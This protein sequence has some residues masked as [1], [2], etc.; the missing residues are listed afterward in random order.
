MLGHVKMPARLTIDKVRETAKSRGY[1]LL[2]TCF[3]DAKTKI[4]L[5][6]PKHGVFEQ[7]IG[8]L[9]SGYGCQKCGREKISESIG[10]SYEETKKIV[11]KEGYSL[12][13]IE[14]KKGIK[15]LT[16]KCDKHG[17]FIQRFHLFRSGHRCK[18][19]SSEQFKD[20]LCINTSDAQKI[21]DSWGYKGFYPKNLGVGR[22]FEVECPKHGKILTTLT[23]LRCG[24]GCFDCGVEKN[25]NKKRYSQDKIA[26]DIEKKGYKLLSVY[27]NNHA[28]L[29][30]ECPI[31]GIFQSRYHDIQQKDAGCPSC[32]SL[33]REK[34]TRQIFESILGASFN[35]T[36]MPDFRMS[37][38]KRSLQLDG[39]NQDLKLGFEYDGE[40]HYNYCGFL[41]TKDTFVRQNYRDLCKDLFCQQLG[42]YLIRVPYYLKDSQMF[43]F[44]SKEIDMWK[45]RT[46][47][48]NINL[49]ENGR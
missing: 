42:V 36:R 47:D 35:S 13:S 26:S 40:Q 2:S 7:R 24:H 48:Y 15:H 21:I 29:D 9:R 12:L 3:E 41:Q 8:Y 5:K 22:K 34:K 32:S 23:D 10:Y 31:H 4:E 16:L 33:K 25:A 45:N 30:L 37:D 43:D 39:Y 19:C 27:Q 17:I 38:T 11:E 18:A 6:C 49:Y 28:I 1:E 20:K 44:I 46:I 14:N